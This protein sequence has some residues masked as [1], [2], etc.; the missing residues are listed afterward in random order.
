MDKNTFSILVR[1]FKFKELFNRM[2]WDRASGSFAL[3]HKDQSYNISIICDKSGFKVLQCCAPSGSPIPSKIERM[4]LQSKLKR[5]FYEHLLIFTDDARQ[6]QIWQYSYKPLGKPLKTIITEYNISQDPG[7]LYQRSSGFIFQIDEEGNITLKDVIK[8]MADAI[9]KNAEKVTKKFYDGFK[10]QHA[11]FLDYII[12]IVG[13]DE[14]KWYASVMLNRLMFCYF[15]QKQGFLDGNI[16]YLNDKLQE[17]KL[18]HGRD[19]FYSFYR[20]FLLQLFHRQLGSPHDESVTGI[21]GKIPYLNGGIFSVHEIEKKYPE[22]INISDEAFSALFSFFDEYQWHLD[23]SETASGRD[24]NPDVIGYIFEKYINDRAQMGAYYT[25]EDITEYIG[26]NTILPYLFDEVQRHYPEAFKPEEELWQKLK[27]SEDLYIYKA[28]KH[29][30]NPED[31]WHD[32]PNDVRAGLDPEQENLVELRRC[33]NRPAPADA[34]LPTEIWREVITRRQRYIELRSHIDNGDITSINDFITYNLDIRQFTLDL[35]NET[36]NTQLVYQ[37]YKALKT[38]TI[39]DPT[40]GSGAFLF[41]AMNILEDLYEVCLIRIHEFDIEN[42]GRISKDIKNDL[43]IIKSSKHPNLQYYIYKSIILNNLYGVDI[44]P[45]AVEIAKLRLFLK[46]VACVDPD[47]HHLNYGLEPLPDIDFNIRCGNTLVGYANWDEIIMD[48][49]SDAITAAENREELPILCDKVAMAY[50]RYKQ[51]QLLGYDDFANFSQARALLHGQLQELTDRL[52]S[53]LHQHSS[54]IPFDKWKV[55]HQPFHWVAEFYEIIHSRKGFDVIIGNPPYVEE[56]I[57]PFVT[58]SLDTRKC[59]NIYAYVTEKSYTLI[60]DVSRISL[61]VP[62]SLTSSVR[63]APLRSVIY[64]ES[65]RLWVSSFALRPQS[66]FKN[67]MQ[68]ISIFLALKSDASYA[69]WTT[70]YTRWT[71]NERDTLFNR[72]SY[73][74]V[75]HDF[76]CIP[77]LTSPI[78]RVIVDR[79]KYVGM[80]I[81]DLLSTNSRALYYHDSGESYWT[82]ALLERPIAY[83]DNVLVTPSQ[84]F[85]VNLPTEVYLYLFAFLNSNF[86]YFLWT[87]FTDCRHLT[88][89]FIQSSRVATLTSAELSDLMQ[90]SDSLSS[91][92]ESCTSTF[93]KRPGYISPEIKMN[94][95]K[96]EIDKLDDYLATHFGFTAEQL[97]Y[98]VN[99]DIKY[100]MGDVGLDE[101]CGNK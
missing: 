54:S 39:L 29:G 47:P 77:K 90:M 57:Y 8:R 17:C 94:R 23:T 71:T 48:I 65:S 95:I 13:E 99:F 20:N 15:I 5:R 74:N 30:I 52:D 3:E 50:E 10:K 97:D 63:M 80:E 36:N 93:E 84:W 69:A 64:R 1:E 12:G 25:K 6:K 62:I 72:L 92:I 22:Q 100:R 68:R 89:Q 51:I 55:T 27:S 14:K 78:G 2:G 9:D 44:M 37:F 82:K 76:S 79:Y 46:L 56:K 91:A 59:G 41:A 16:H 45:E 49:E 81:K 31:I 53:M 33:W 58:S 85:S 75:L 38:I 32:L 73:V 87:S 21:F 24:I 67:V 83:R 26:K 70:G 40:C 4:S 11:K 28:V 42:P 35:L 43:E 60:H 88:K 19:Q 7:L 18:I 66:L 86:F 98:I 61:V 101:I 96:R 34:A